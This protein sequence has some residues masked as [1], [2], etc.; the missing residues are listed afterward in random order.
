MKRIYSFLIVLIILG[1]RTET[2]PIEMKFAGDWKTDEGPYVIFKTNTNTKS[3]FK[4]G[5]SGTFEFGVRND[6]EPLTGNYLVLK[7]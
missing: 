2:E 6:P 4:G 1:C 7:N 3:K 5:E